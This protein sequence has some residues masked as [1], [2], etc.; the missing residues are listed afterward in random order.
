MFIAFVLILLFIL[1]GVLVWVY[2]VFAPFTQNIWDVIDFNSAYYWALAWIERANLI[3]KYRAPWFE[4]S[5]WYFGATNYWPKSDLMTGFWNL[6]NWNN[7]ISWQIKSRTTSI[8]SSGD[9]NVEYLLASNDSTNFNEL[10]YYTPSKIYLYV[11]NT[12]SDRNAYSW[13]STFLYFTWWSFSGYF[14]LPSKVVNNFGGALLCDTCDSNWDLVK[15]EVA[16]N[17]GLD[18]YYSWTQFSILPNEE[19]FYSSWRQIDWS[20]DTVLRESIIN[21][22]SGAVYFG[23]VE[24][25]YHGWH[26]FNPILQYNNT[27]TAHNL[28][29]TDPSVIKNMTFKQILTNTDINPQVT[30]LEFSFG[31][32]DLLRSTNGSIYPFLEYQLNFPSAVSNNFYTI[33]W[34]SIVWNYDVKIIMKKWT[35]PDSTIGNFTIIF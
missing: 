11:D 5:G 31:L 25:P 2:S 8:P 35:N 1:L 30:W 7:W 9:G 32:V 10:P 3:L 14:R 22:S 16:V 12:P 29:S 19:I 33:Q 27:L 15:N 18:G 23:F 17:R 34:E 28:I 20:K 4:G 21:N 13:V 6:N 24:S 26:A